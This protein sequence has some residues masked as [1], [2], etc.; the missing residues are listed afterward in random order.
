MQTNEISAIVVVLKTKSP[1]FAAPAEPAG[2]KPES[3]EFTRGASPR[4]KGG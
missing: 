4:G 3:M 2:V 1:E